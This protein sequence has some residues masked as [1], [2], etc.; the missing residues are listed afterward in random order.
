MRRQKSVPSTASHFRQQ[1]RTHPGQQKMAQN[2]IKKDNG[3][4]DECIHPGVCPS[5][6]AAAV[7]PPKVPIMHEMKTCNKTGFESQQAGEIRAFREDLPEAK[8]VSCPS[9]A[10]GM[11]HMCPGQG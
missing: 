4:T 7:V 3:E 11:M 5:I 8:G 1:P 2:P 9:C 10:Y 6:K